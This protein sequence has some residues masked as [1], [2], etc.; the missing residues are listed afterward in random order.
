MLSSKQKFW[1]SKL[2]ARRL[3]IKA[4]DRTF[5]VSICPCWESMSSSEVFHP[6][7][8]DNKNCHQTLCS[9]A[10]SLLLRV[11][12]TFFD[13][14]FLYL[15]WH[16]QVNI[17]MKLRWTLKK[18]TAN[19]VTPE[20]K[21]TSRRCMPHKLATK[22]KLKGLRYTSTCFCFVFLYRRRISVQNWRCFFSIKLC[23]AGFKK[24]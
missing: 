15:T 5:N 20:A 22:L 3:S 2:L 24:I 18:V 21:R 6:S 10:S 11:S 17:N 9:P 23:V 16:W 13:L 19:I 12:C 1:A 7:R 14:V 8:H 4:A